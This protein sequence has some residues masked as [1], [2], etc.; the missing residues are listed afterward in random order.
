MPQAFAGS[1]HLVLVALWLPR[2]HSLIKDLQE[3][4][5]LWGQA[6]THCMAGT[7]IFDFHFQFAATDL[8][9]RV[10]GRGRAG[11]ENGIANKAA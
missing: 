1:P 6:T 2:L 11:G 10:D 4:R 9:I 5:W 7:F 3:L 8:K